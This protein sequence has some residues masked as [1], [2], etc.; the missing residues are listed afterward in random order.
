MIHLCHCT[1][2]CNSTTVFCRI[3]SRCIANRTV[4]GG[5]EP[6]HA[7]IQARHSV[8]TAEVVLLQPQMFLLIIVKSFFFLITCIILSVISFPL[9]N[10]SPPTKVE[11][12][13]V[14]VVSDGNSLEN[15]RIDDCRMM[16][17]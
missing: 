4:E 10:L 11:Q 1:L 2:C 14:R 9:A 13:F 12:L 5:R 17:A 3:T 16:E 6:V 15:L 7:R 8:I